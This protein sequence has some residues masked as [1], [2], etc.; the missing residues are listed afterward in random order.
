MQK[1]DDNTQ[2]GKDVNKVKVDN[3]HDGKD[4]NKVDNTHDGKDVNKVKFGS[5]KNSTQSLNNSMLD[6]GVVQNDEVP[7]IDLEAPE[8]R[9]SKW[10]LELDLS[11]VYAIKPEKK[12]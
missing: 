10:L 5:N 11:S 7:K 1:I 8:N 9:I 4:V 12:Q 3:T 6:H 2:D